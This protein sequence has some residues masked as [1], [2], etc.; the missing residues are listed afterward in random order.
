MAALLRR[1]GYT[2]FAGISADAVLDQLSQARAQPDLI[3]TDLH[4]G[5]TNGL[6]EIAHMREV[7]RVPGMTA[8]LVTGDLDAGA[9]SRAAQARVY[10]AHKPLA[11]RKLADLVAQLVKAADAKRPDVDVPA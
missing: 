2:V 9:A 5:T 7:L 4:L 1:W 3:I 8:L 6:A 11:P 10:V